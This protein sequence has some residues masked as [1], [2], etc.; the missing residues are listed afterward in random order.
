MIHEVNLKHFS[1]KVPL[2]PLPHVVHFPHTILP[3]HIFEKRYRVMIKDVLEGERLIGMAVLQPGWEENYEGNP[4]IYPVACLGRVI[5]TEPLPN[6]RSNILLLGLKRVRIQEIVT[7]F[8]YRT[9]RV[10][11][12]EDTLEGLEKPE[13]RQFKHRLLELYSEMVIE[14]AG[15]DK[16]FPPLSSLKLEAGA[17]ADALAACIGLSTP[18]LV[19]LLMEHRVSER[20]RFLEQRLVEKLRQGGPIVLPPN[21]P[22]IPRT[23]HLN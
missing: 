17:L 22:G 6:G 11:I 23:I 2:F 21:T 13:L 16:P 1:G 7:P 9:A 18:D 8:P 4:N 12:V 15:A 14:F 10:E 19:H 5:K 20:F 3:L